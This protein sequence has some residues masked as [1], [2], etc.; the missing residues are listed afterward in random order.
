MHEPACQ[1]LSGVGATVVVMTELV[2]VVRGHARRRYP[3]ERATVHLS[4]NFEGSDREDV[5]R[6][7]VELQ[8]PLTAD[9]TALREAG[10]ITR[11]SSDQLRVFS[12]RPYREKGKR[13]LM[14]RA[15]ISV[16]AE[17]T[18][19]EQLSAFL[20]RWAGK[21]GLDVG[22]T[23]WDV[24]EENRRRYEADLQA[25]AV[26]AATARAQ[27]YAT[28]AGRGA[29]VAVQLADPGMLVDDQ[30]G[31]PARMAMMPGPDALDAGPPALELRPDDIDIAVLVDA[32]FVAE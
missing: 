32:R 15:A 10:S 14:F 18:D 19:F 6:R 27:A 24:T 30:P 28:A 29:V 9:L 25:E 2:V 3:D 5:Y 31:R 12:F 22:Y 13:P 21:D 4:T 11:W 20:D 23:R 26:V 8:E 17:F 7:A 16:D 1:T